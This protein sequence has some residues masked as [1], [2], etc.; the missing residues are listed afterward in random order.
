M[1]EM[2]MGANGELTATELKRNAVPKNQVMSADNS[3]KSR[4]ALVSTSKVG[5]ALTIRYTENQEVKTRTLVLS[6]Q[7]KVTPT[8]ANLNTVAGRTIQMHALSHGVQVSG[9]QGA[10]QIRVVTAQGQVMQQLQGHAQ[11]SLFVP[12]SHQ[13]QSQY[14][15]LVR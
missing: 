15:K 12:L 4:M 3:V 7:A 6:T 11:G 1:Y 10:Y 5:D 13:G 9:L 2:K 8:D 14:M